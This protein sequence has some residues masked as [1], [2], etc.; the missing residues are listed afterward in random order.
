MNRADLA[1]VWGNT[2]LPCFLVGDPRQ[3]PPT[4]MSDM[5]KDAA[6]NQRHRL[7]NDAK[8]SALEWI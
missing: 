5:G 1:C 6:G 8:V 3:L 2:L 7:A 4:V